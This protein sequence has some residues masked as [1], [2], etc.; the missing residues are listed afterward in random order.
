MNGSTAQFTG[1]WI[2]IDSRKNQVSCTRLGIT[3]TRRYG[4]AHERN[5]FKRIVRES[6]R[7]SYPQLPSGFDLNV[8]PRTAAKTANMQDVM[9]ELLKALTPKQTTST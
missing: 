6:F 4:D 9:S 1:Q 2:I 8:K 5:R 7:L 3:V